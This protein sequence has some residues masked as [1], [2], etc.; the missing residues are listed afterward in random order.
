MRIQTRESLMKFTSMFRTRGRRAIG[1][2]QAAI[3]ATIE[4]APMRAYGSAIADDISI[5]IGRELADAQVYVAL[6]RLMAQ[7]LLTSHPE[8]PRGT[9]EVTTSKVTRGRP[10]KYYSLT[11]LGKRTLEDAAAYTLVTR[12]FV[13]S[14]KRGASHE[15]ETKGP[16]PAPVVG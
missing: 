10:R 6:R 12:H 11:A 8:H 5:K 9:S 4:A 7:G 2:V 3:L 16:H 14:T 1:L 15:T 13:H